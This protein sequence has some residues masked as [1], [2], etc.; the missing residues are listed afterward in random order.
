M[1][2]GL[3]ADPKR[4]TNFSPAHPRAPRRMDPTMQGKPALVGDHMRGFYNLPEIILVLARE[5][6]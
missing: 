4:V 1:L 2:S 6:G 3:L 5:W